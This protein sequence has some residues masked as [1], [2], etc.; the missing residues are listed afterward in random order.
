M[1]VTLHTSLGD[2]KLEL[3]CEQAP[4]TTKVSYSSYTLN[5]LSPSSSLPTLPSPT[6]LMSRCR[7]GVGQNFLALCASGVYDGTV[8]HRLMRG[9]MMQGGDPT[10]T[11]KGGSA[12]HGG[13]LDD[14][15]VDALTHNAR[16]ILSMANKGPNT[17]G[18]TTPTHSVA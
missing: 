15:V 4:K 13:R 6:P 1:S 9:F 8:F 2:L 14:E 7:C 5:P 10:G 12:Y 16:G 11:G 17:A 3:F 18:N